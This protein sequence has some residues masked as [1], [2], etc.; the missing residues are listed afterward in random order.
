MVLPFVNA[1]YRTR[2][3]VVDFAP[4]DVEDFAHCMADPEWNTTPNSGDR[5][6]GSRWEWGFVLLVEDA[7]AP[8]GKAPERLRLFVNNS[9]GQGLLKMSA[10]EYVQAHQTLSAT[11]LISP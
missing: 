2:V 9:A 7:N 1:K 11:V 8:M 4:K 3:R 6:S 5:R 10:S